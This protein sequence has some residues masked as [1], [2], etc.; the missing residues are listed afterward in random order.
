[1]IE[2]VTTSSEPPAL[3]PQTALGRGALG[4]AQTADRA[5]GAAFV[6]RVRAL[7]AFAGQRPASADRGQGEP[8]AMSAAR[9]AARPELLLPVSEWAAQEVSIGLTCSRR[10]AEDLLDQ[11]LM[12]SRV[13]RVLAATE[14]GLLTV[15]HLWCLEQHVASIADPALRAELEAVLVDWVAARAGRGTITTPA[16]LRE[17]VLRELARRNARDRAQQAIT[18]LRK[19]GVFPAAESGEGLAGLLL[20]GSIPEIEALRAALAA[21]ADALPPDPADT[22]TREQK[23]LDVLLDLVLRPGEH[24]MPPVRVALTLVAAVST[25]LGGDAP[26]ELNGR[27]V[28]AETAR[29]LLNALTG[30][31]LGDGV[32]DE[33]RRLADGDGEPGADERADAASAG[34]DDRF[35]DAPGWEPWEPE[36]AAAREQQAAGW[37]RRLAAG[38]YDDPEPMPDEVWRASV[39]A[40]LADERFEAELDRE[41]A[42]AQDRW[43]R[44]YEA[45]QHPDPDEDFPDPPPP[46]E[47]SPG[48]GWWAAAEQALERARG[49]QQQAEQALARAGARVRLAAQVDAADEQA[50][51]TGS[52]GRVEA[53]EDAMTALLAA[54]AADRAALHALLRRTAGGGLAD[55]PRLALVDALSGALVALTDLPGLTRAVRDGVAVGAPPPTDG[56]RPGAALDRFIRHRDRRCRFPGCRRPVSTGELDHRIA[57]PDGP[58]DVTN[59]AGLCTGDHRGKHQAPGFSYDGRPDGTLLVTTPS[60]ITVTTEAPPF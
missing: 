17:K 22:R 18:A 38:V 9:W 57:W 55:R 37:E 42:D 52:G 46:A 20:V 48:G 29:Q 3:G 54:T 21:C 49:V 34:S 5:M 44:E 10:R 58:T 28:S 4:V 33:L 32:L 14:A 19:R 56:Y 26:G 35:L 53:A 27:I 59:L 41:L 15:G 11:A 45:G 2:C 13:P 60:G 24:G 51:R 40:R 31:G 36:M 50:W 39:A 47:P 1:M 7:A 6:A 23:L 25:V 16:Q 43:W 12:L 30:A 8:G